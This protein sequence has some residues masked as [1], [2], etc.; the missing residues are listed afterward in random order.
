MQA[1]ENI[2]SSFEHVQKSPLY[3]N[4][5]DESCDFERMSIFVRVFDIEIFGDDL[6]LATLTSCDEIHEEDLFKSFDDFMTK[7]KLSY[8]RIVSISTDGAPA[9][10]GQEKRLVK[11]IRDE[12]SDVFG[13]K[14]LAKEKKCNCSHIITLVNYN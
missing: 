8:D 11:K 7:S 6:V 9:M 10:I 14:E 12:N 13:V 5:P 3:D 4:A 2:K 1:A